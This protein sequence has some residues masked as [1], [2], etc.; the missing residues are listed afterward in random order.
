MHVDFREKADKSIRQ[1]VDTLVAHHN[2]RHHSALL[3]AALD[4]HVKDHEG[5]F[6]AGKPLVDDW[7]CLR[8]MLEKWEQQCG[9]LN[10]YSMKYSRTLATLCNIGVKVVDFSS[11]VDV[12]CS[13]DALQ[14]TEL[15]QKTIKSSVYV[16]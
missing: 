5:R 3:T 10:D 15:F 14:V 4:M 12:A 11:V 8:G 7:S 16:S 2:L 13:N 6:A 9:K 1:I